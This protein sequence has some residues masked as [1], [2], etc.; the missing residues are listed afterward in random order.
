MSVE[1]SSVKTIAVFLHKTIK[2]ELD[3]LSNPVFLLRLYFHTRRQAA[4]IRSLLNSFTTLEH[5]VRWIIGFA[6]VQSWS[7]NTESIGNTILGAKHINQINGA[8]YVEGRK[9]SEQTHA[10]LFVP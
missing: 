5:H 6:Q 9:L 8:S 3:K 7:N 1:R 10:S 2:F 4:L